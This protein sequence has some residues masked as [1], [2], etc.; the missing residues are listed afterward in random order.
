MS[1]K[2]RTRDGLTL[3]ARAGTYVVMLGIDR[4]EADCAGLRGF[5]IHRTDHTEGEAYHL[6]G[7]KTFAATDPGFEAGS[8]VSTRDHP[9]QTFTWSDY[10]AKPD[11]D[12]TYRVDA[13][14]G[15]PDGLTVDASVEV[16][17][18]TESVG[19]AVHDVHFNR[20]VAASQ[21]YARRFGN[22]PPSEVGQP[23]FDWL[24]RGLVEALLGFIGRAGAG[25]G[26]RV[27]AYEFHHLPVLE[28]L[29]AAVDRG[30]DVRIVYDAKQAD[31]RTRNEDA[32]AQAGLAGAVTPRS[33][34]PSYIQHNKF[35]VRLDGGQPTE[36]LTG[37]TNFSE[38]GIFGHANNLHIVRDRAV[39]AAYLGYW[40][41]LVRDRPNRE[42]KPDIDTMVDIP[43][44]WPRRG[45]T[46]VFSPRSETDA[47]DFYAR[48]ARLANDS[49]F[50]TFAF[51]M[52]G[53]V[54]AAYRDGEA[55]LRYAVMERKIRG[56]A[57]GPERDAAE[58]AIDD[59]RAMPE[60]RFAI[61]SRLT[62]NTLD[63]WVAERN[64]GLNSHVRY[65]H[66]KFMLIDPTTSSPIVITGSANFSK[67]SSVD[68]D[69]NM[70]VIRDNRRV[71]DIYLGEFVRLYRH[72]AF[73]EW[74]ES[75]P[76][77]S[78][79]ALANLE[80]GQWWHRYFGDGSRSRQREF[81]AA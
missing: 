7:M 35:V 48:M 26:L 69:E 6:R 45:T 4:A 42:A 65:I 1:K 37:G 19:S 39:A 58:Q 51:G 12:Y 11:H 36:V 14:V 3:R 2:R 71:A 73:R 32:I 76:P 53:S 78:E 79:P 68:N 15:P 57:P 64:T 18:T 5:A 10:T 21:A 74:L 80:L 34:H 27:A 8:T 59:L 75:R 43:T 56:M 70:L 67:A 33:T 44:G 63:R 50:A 40:D 66:N 31:L 72:H 55:P 49:L 47:L 62:S 20:G 52:H 77:G 28:A 61:G 29:R 41:N 17:I 16:P 46:A 30:A 23:A 9:L 54:Q 60:N 13:L 81:W 38:G 22:R 25:T 24:S